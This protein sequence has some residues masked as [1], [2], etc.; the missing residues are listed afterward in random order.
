M[1]DE[2]Q[3]R[4]RDFRRCICPESNG[5]EKISSDWI[6]SILLVDIGHESSKDVNQEWNLFMM[7]LR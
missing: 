6:R 5:A 4:K 2:D 7:S 1:G 3:G